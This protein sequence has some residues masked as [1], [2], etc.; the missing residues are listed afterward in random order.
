[1]IRQSIP[2][3]N[4]KKFK[5][6]IAITIEGIFGAINLMIK[7]SATMVSGQPITNLRISIV[8]FFIEH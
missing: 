3:I 5:L 6:L 4:N 1:M 8:L 2:K 7:N